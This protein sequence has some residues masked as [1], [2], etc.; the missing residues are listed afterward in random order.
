MNK[1]TILAFFV[2]LGLATTAE[3]AFPEGQWTGKFWDVKTGKLIATDGN[4][5][6]GNGTWYNTNAP[7]MQGKWFM[8][9][10]EIYIHAYSTL[11]NKDVYSSQLQ[12]LSP[13]LMGGRHQHWTTD[14]SL[15]I[16]ATTTLS[17]SSSACLPPA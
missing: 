14:G 10:D 9:G 11:E 6:V 13:T 2:L 17:Y 5:I 4:C 1:T 8:K 12:K 7:G 16:F 3:A 15:A